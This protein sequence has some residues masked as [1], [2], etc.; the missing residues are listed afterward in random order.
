MGRLLPSAHGLH[1]RSN[2]SPRFYGLGWSP[3]ENRGSKMQPEWWHR[4]QSAFGT[5]S[6]AFVGASLQQLIAA[7]RL[8]NSGICEIA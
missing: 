3:G 4:L 8:P 2:T 5:A 7:A 6:S 1:F